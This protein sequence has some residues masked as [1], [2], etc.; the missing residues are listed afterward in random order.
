MVKKNC[1]LIFSAGI[2]NASVKAAAASRLRVKKL[3]DK[4]IHNGRTTNQTAKLAVAAGIPPTNNNTDNINNNH[5]IS[6]ESNDTIISL[7]EA[8]HFRPLS[9]QRSVSSEDTNGTNSIGKMGTNDDDSDAEPRSLFQGISL[10]DFEQHRKMVE[11]QNKQK[12]EMLTK[13][14]EQR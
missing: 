5:E 6:L 12:K 4:Q 11:E 7:Q 8:V 14:I 9:T 3:P 10:K 13:A 1:S 2:Q